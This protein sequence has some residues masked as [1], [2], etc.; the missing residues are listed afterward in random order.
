MATVQRSEFGA[1]ACKAL[2]YCDQC[3]QPFELF[4][5]I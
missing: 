2:M 3:R 1:T 5:A 4:K